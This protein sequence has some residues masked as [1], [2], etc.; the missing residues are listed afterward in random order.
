MTDESEVTSA[1]RLHLYADRK[2]TRR[3]LTH[4]F[5]NKVKRQSVTG[6]LGRH[7]PYIGV[8]TLLA[9]LPNHTP[10]SV[11]EARAPGDPI[12]LETFSS[13]NYLSKW[14]TASDSF[15]LVFVYCFFSLEN[16]F[17]VLFIKKWCFIDY[18]IVTWNRFWAGGEIS[19]WR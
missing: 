15:E 13:K 4:R 7:S 11:E 9:L 17:K 10:V 18:S 2:T 12:P 1:C 5:I 8:V 19:F 14:L 6:Q 16:Y 3:K